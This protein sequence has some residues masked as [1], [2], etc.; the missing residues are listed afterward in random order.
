LELVTFSVR[1]PVGNVQ[2]FVALLDG[3]QDGAIVDLTAAYTAYLAAETDEPTPAEL[4][5]L[6]TPWFVPGTQT[7]GKV[8]H[9]D[10]MQPRVG[11]EEKS[12][13]TRPQPKAF[14]S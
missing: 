6:R 12:M 10:K 4:A 5:A 9:A 1:T 7:L 2:R 11:T 14:P 3:N 13:A 8:L